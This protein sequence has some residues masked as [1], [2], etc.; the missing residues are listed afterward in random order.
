MAIL[1][2]RKARAT[3]VRMHSYMAVSLGRLRAGLR[4]LSQTGSRAIGP[5]GDS[6]KKETPL[7]AGLQ[8]VASESLRKDRVMISSDRT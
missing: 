2:G 6:A 1:S 8:L 3:A 4:S 7:V 5:G